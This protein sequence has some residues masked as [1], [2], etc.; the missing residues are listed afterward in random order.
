MNS[1]IH[2]WYDLKDSLIRPKMSNQGEY[3]SRVKTV[4]EQQLT[5]CTFS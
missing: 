2:L 4:T 1:Y 3:Y 5:Y